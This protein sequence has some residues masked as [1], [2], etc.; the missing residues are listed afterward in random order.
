MARAR[1]RTKLQLKVNKPPA[2]K[3]EASEHHRRKSGLWYGAAVVGLE[4]DEVKALVQNIATC[5]NE[6]A[7]Q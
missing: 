3:N 7:E 1:K 2:V 5:T 4:P 6:D